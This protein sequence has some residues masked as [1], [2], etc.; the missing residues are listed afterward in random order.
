MADQGIRMALQT[1]KAYRHHFDGPHLPVIATGS[2][3]KADEALCPLEP[4][5]M[6]A[7]FA[8][9]VVENHARALDLHWA[10]DSFDNAGPAFTLTRT[11]FLGACTAYWVLHPDSSRER[12]TRSLRVTLKDLQ[13]STGRFRDFLSDPAV[14]GPDYREGRQLANEG[15]RSAQNRATQA[16][17]ALTGLGIEQPSFNETRMIEESFAALG[18]SLGRLLGLDAW[19]RASAAVHARRWV[20]NGVGEQYTDKYGRTIERSGF[21]RDDFERLLVATARL[22]DEAWDRWE[23]LNRGEQSPTFGQT[24]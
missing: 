10:H 9:G 16:R 21:A 15:L 20:I 17:D 13:D 3:F 8:L 19:R 1:F 2:A 24:H 4:P 22:Y 12:V 23:R 5:Y 11:A 7:W 6:R 14:A 18:D